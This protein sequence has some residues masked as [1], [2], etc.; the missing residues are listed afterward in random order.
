MNDKAPAFIADKRAM[1]PIEGGV[2]VRV[3]PEAL[4]EIEFSQAVTHIGIP[5]D[6]ALAFGQSLIK[7]AMKARTLKQVMG[8]K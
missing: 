2:E 4:V 1:R 7:A 5:H 8:G 6:Q 3:S